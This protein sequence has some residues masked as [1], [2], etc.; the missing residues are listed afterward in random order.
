MVI[1]KQAC[2]T[3]LV[4]HFYF[5]IKYVVAFYNQKYTNTSMTLTFTAF[6]ED[7]VQNTILHIINYSAYFIL[8]NIHLLDLILQ[9]PIS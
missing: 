8:C 9:L 4:N 1:G 3:D 2:K 7:T 5:P 6:L